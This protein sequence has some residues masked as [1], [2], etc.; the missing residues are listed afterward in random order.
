MSAKSTGRGSRGKPSPKSTLSIHKGTGYWCKKINGHVYY[1][2]R[3]AD[4]PKGTAALEQFLKEEA[5]LRAGREPRDTDPNALTVETL[6]FR[7]LA[8]KEAL[9]DNGELSPRTYRGYFDTC[10]GTAETIGRKRAVVD[11]RP[12]DFGELRK[13]L[14]K[15]RG[16]VALGNEMQRVRSIFKFAFDEGLIDAPVRFGQTFKSP[17]PDVIR[18]ARE[19]HRAEHGDRMF[20]TAQLRAILAAAG[21]PLKTMVML[22]ANCGLGQSDLAALPVR[23]VNL[24][25][26]W[27]DF[28]RVKTGVSR[29]IPLWPQ[30]IATIR[31]WLPLRPKA[32]DPADA[33]LLF[34]TVRGARWVKACKAKPTAVDG[35]EK[36]PGGAPKDAIGQE[37]NKVV[38]G[39]GLKRPGVAFYAIRHGFETVAGETAD[40]V[41]VD[42]IMGHV[43]QGMSAAYRERISDDR[44]RR[45]ATHVRSWLFGDEP[46]DTT[47]SDG[48]PIENAA[49][50]HQEPD[51]GNHGPALRLFI[52]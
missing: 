37:F 2:G 40:Q 23:A 6:C 19:T 3:V 47:G 7:F 4:D 46:D 1:F 11:L 12:E 44:L 16:A 25:S 31:E 17:K 43:A 45:V 41:A 15:T 10:Q 29:R 42:A 26:G 34:L 48:L 36:K 52:A 38:E 32:K 9:R 50:P 49:E 35:E 5:D 13:K 18:R 8:H 39:L 30:T 28:A 33:G 21:Q 51:T 24:D 22:A 27:L 20:E 14:V